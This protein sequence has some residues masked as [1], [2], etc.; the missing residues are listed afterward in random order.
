MLLLEAHEA[1]QMQQP[2]STFIA[3]DLKQRLQ[4]L[5]LD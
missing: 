5:C 3:S 4:K 1:Q 2:P